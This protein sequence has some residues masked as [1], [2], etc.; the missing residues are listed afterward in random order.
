MSKRQILTIL[1]A[2]PQFIKA[3]V[4]SRAI[5]E[6]EGLSERLVHTGQHYD[7]NMSSVFFEEMGIPFPSF[8]LG[9][10][11]GTHAENTGRTLEAVERLILSER[12]DFVMV[13]GDTDATLAGALAA[14]K[15]NTPVVHIEAGLRSFNRAM[16]EEVNRVLTDHVSSLLFAPSD[17]AIHNLIKEG[18]LGEHVINSGDVMFDAVRQFS[19]VAAKK[20]QVL[21]QLRLEPK[22]YVLATVHRKENADNPKRLTQILEGFGRSGMQILLPLHPR[23]RNRLQE[24][25]IVPAKNIRIIEPV[26]YLDMMQLEACSMAIATDSGGV[27]KESY[28]HG[29]PGVILRNETEWVELVDIGANRLVGADSAAIASALNSLPSELPKMALYGDGHAAQKI[30]ERLACE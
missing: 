10:G 21:R 7:M 24:F 1:G 13:Y 6:F 4:V 22:R 28:F 3:A 12:P 14:S 19:A 18:I 29:V 23:T 5:A 25:G 15:A 2:R 30:A 16:P 17:I 9:I 8:S 11:G 20:S 26:G 27:Q